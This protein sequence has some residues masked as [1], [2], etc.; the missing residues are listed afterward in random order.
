MEANFDEVNFSQ[1]SFC[2]KLGYLYGLLLVHKTTMI[3]VLNDQDEPDS[4]KF[5]YLIVLANSSGQVFQVIS[6]L[7]KMREQLR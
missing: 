5:L 1:I 3:D 4:K 6:E 2:E 7:I